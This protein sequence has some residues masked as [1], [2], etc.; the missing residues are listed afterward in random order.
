MEK[1]FKITTS[2][3]V[4]ARPSALLVSA[5]T[6]FIS[7]VELIYNGK[8]ANLKSIMAVMTQSIPTGSVVTISAEGADA[9]AL[10]SKVTNVII[11]QGIGEEC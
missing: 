9:E 1:T 5:V 7:N 3:G 11:S 2:E 8:S 10:M 4:H 6:P